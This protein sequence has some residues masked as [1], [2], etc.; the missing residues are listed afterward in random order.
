MPPTLRTCAPGW[1]RY[2]SFPDSPLPA[3]PISDSGWGLKKF[4]KRA[5]SGSAPAYI[6]GIL[7]GQRASAVNCTQETGKDGTKYEASETPFETA[8]APLDAGTLYIPC[9]RQAGI[10]PLRLCCRAVHA[11]DPG[12]RHLSG[13][14]PGLA[15]CGD[16]V[17]RGGGLCGAPVFRHAP[18]GTGRRVGR[19][20]WGFPPLI[21]L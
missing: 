3:L 1:T 9:C 14:R 17:R 4:C 18:G 15:E 6:G 8:G 7:A 2:G 20:P 19:Q 13:V 5:R 12:L 16:P 10:Q 11:G 21:N